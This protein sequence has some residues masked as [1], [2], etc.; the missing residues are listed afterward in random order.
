MANLRAAEWYAEIFY[1]VI[2]RITLNKVIPHRVGKPRRLYSWVITTPGL[3]GTV[4]EVISICTS[5][6]MPYILYNLPLVI[7]Y[8]RAVMQ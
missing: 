3:E 6:I 4:G 8:E 2:L 5:N 7:L 1:Q